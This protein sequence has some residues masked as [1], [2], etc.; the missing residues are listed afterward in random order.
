MCLL[1]VEIG[2]EVQPVAAGHEYVVLPA[3]IA[4]E[5]N[6]N[7]DTR[8]LRNVVK[9]RVEMPRRRFGLCGERK[10]ALRDILAPPGERA[11]HATIGVKWV[12]RKRE[13]SR[14][15]R[16]L[17]PLLEVVQFAPNALDQLD[18]GSLR[19]AD[20]FRRRRPKDIT[21]DDHLADSTARLGKFNH[22]FQTGFRR[23]R[24]ALLPK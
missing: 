22:D 1:L 7:R 10:P 19:V 4:N 14:N 13:R 9:R 24:C 11:I 5:L 20:E 18:D 23:L 21:R 3:R 8:R 12:E 17:P 6:Q 2:D 15:S 16:M